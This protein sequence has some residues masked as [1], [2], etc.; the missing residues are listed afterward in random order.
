MS[1]NVRNFRQSACGVSLMRMSYLGLML[2]LFGCTARD[3]RQ[4][5]GEMD[6]AK[7]LATPPAAGPHMVSNILERIHLGATEGEVRKDFAN[8]NALPPH[9]TKRAIGFT[10]SDGGRPIVVVCYFS[11]TGSTMRLSRV[12][13]DLF[14]TRPTDFDAQR[15][16][17]IVKSELRKRLGVPDLDP[18]KASLSDAPPDYRMSALSTWISGDTV[19]TLALALLEDGARESRSALAMAVADR[20]HDPV[21]M[22]NAQEA[23]RRKP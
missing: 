1:S 13:V 8:W 12:N 2:A 18:A 17:D 4:R 21:A 3:E 7:V 5:Q 22:M 23:K 11:E 6:V 15:Q 16:Y 10:S 19:T 20:V 9:P 14:P